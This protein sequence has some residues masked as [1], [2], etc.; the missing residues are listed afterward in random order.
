MNQFS[1]YLKRKNKVEQKIVTT[2]NILKTQKDF[3]DKNG[4][5]LSLVVR[6]AIDD[7]IKNK[8]KTSA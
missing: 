2:V 1:R 8:N 6:D 7:L 3:L 5:N 4:L